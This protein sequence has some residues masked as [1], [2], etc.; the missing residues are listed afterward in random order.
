MNTI[1]CITVTHH[2][3]YSVITLAEEDG[4][5]I[6]ECRMTFT[7]EIV[8]HRFSDYQKAAAG[9]AAC[10]TASLDWAAPDE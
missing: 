2:G 5:Y 8:R 4:L 7:S 6:V 10:V 1:A 3:K 9:Y